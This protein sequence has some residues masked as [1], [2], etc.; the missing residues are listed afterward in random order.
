MLTL[1]ERD[2]SHCGI[3]AVITD[4]QDFSDVNKPCRPWSLVAS[5]P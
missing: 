2:F 3:L 1:L 4:P 5:D